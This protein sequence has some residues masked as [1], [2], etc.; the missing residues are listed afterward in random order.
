MVLLLPL[1]LTAVCI[2]ASLALLGEF[3]G[4]LPRGDSR[5]SLRRQQQQHQQPQGVWIVMA[6]K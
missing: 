1:T 2:S 3:L 5:P 4:E 6:N